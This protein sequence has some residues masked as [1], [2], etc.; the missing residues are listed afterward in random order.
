M[1]RGMRILAFV[2]VFLLLY[3]WTDDVLQTK[4]TDGIGTLNKFY[5]LPPD[6]IDMLMVGSSHIGMNIDP[7]LLWNEYGIASYNLWGGMQPVW[8]SYYYVK[9]ALKYQ[10]PKL[11][12]VDVFL[13]SVMGE[14][15]DQ[16]VAMKNIQAMKPSFDKLNAA[17]TSFPTWRKGLEAFWGMPVYHARFDELQQAD[18]QYDAFTKELALEQ[19]NDNVIMKQ[20]QEPYPIRMLDY[21]SISES[22]PISEKSEKYLRKLITLCE[23]HDAELLLMAAPFGATEE[24]Y[25]RL[26]RVAHIAEELDVP[27]VDCLSDVQAYDVVPETDF[28]DNSHLNKNGIVKFTRRMAEKHFT[29]YGLADRRG[30][31]SHI[32]ADVT[33]TAEASTALWEMSQQF[34][35][36]GSTRFVDTGVKLY[37]NQFNS[38]TLLTS[39]DMTKRAGDEVYLSCFSEVA[40]EGYRGLLIRRKTDEWLAVKLGDNTDVDIFVDAPV[41]NLAVI[42]EQDRYTVYANGQEI[43]KRYEIPCSAAYTGTLLVGCQELSP[44]GEKFRYSMTK[45]MDLEVHDRVL[46]EAEILAWQPDVL[47][48]MPLSLGLDGTVK[49]I[50][51]MPEQFMG[52]SDLYAQGAYLDTGMQLFDD[53]ATRFTLFARISAGMTDADNVFFSAFSEV[54]GEYRGLLVRQLDDHQLNVIV[55]NNHGMTIPCNPGQM[56]DLAI[57]KDRD[58]YSIYAD[59]VL[60]AESIVSASAPYEGTLLVGA[61]HDAEGRI[62]RQSGTKVHSLMVRSGAMNADEI[63]AWTIQDAPIPEIRV[64]TSVNYELKDGFLGNGESRFVDTGVQLYDMTDKDWTLDILLTPEYGKETGVYVSCF[65]EETG[66]YRGFMLRQSDGEN[67]TL[68]VG[69]AVTHQIQLRELD[70]ALH[71]VVVKR[72]AQYTVCRDGQL[73]AVLTSDCDAYEGNLLVGCQETAEGD[74]F[75]FS[76]ARITLLKVVDGAISQEDA[77]AQSAIPEEKGRF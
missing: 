20:E 26:N 43:V 23:A 31:S 73:E 51:E 58:T 21:A 70:R 34:A 76:D 54:P 18:F 22:L 27:Y 52:N 50:Y 2:L 8:N 44:G 13:C 30:D 69:D 47:P 60:A 57:V 5:E 1:K 49:T 6:S 32:W 67:L 38:W 19:I 56:I 25:K 68:F 12:V 11:V 74:K 4:T 35:G 48:E 77:I 33:E 62:F 45:V 17:M 65:S 53:A 37:E 3:A 55:G 39:L 75:R 63:K 36:D 59:G 41:I 40:E 64:P 7:T 24:E 42:K 16:A 15:S 10:S 28:W 72:G 71:L 9:E 61:Q 46:S 14:Y 29:Q 66:R